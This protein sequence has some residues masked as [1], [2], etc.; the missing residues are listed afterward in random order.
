MI[1]GQEKVQG[2]FSSYT[3]LLVIG[4]MFSSVEKMA[5][6]VMGPSSAQG[7]GRPSKKLL[8]RLNR[9]IH[10]RDIS[11]CM[12]RVS[13]ASQSPVPDGKR[14]IERHFQRPTARVRRLQRT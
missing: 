4:I 3:S 13:N 14:P 9:T 12:P 10:K 11:G 6:G 1:L 5:H 8:M 7:N 2:W